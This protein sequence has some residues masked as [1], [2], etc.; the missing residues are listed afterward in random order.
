M[1]REVGNSEVEEQKVSKVKNREKN[2]KKYIS[3]IWSNMTH[4]NIPIIGVPQKAALGK[5]FDEIMGK[6]FHN[7]L[8]I[9]HPQIQEI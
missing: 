3:G 4:F 9:T 2:T 1:G 5:I 7:W 6:H 8:K